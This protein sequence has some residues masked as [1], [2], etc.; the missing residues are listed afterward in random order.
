MLVGKL[1]ESHGCETNAHVN[2]VIEGRKGDTIEE[3]F[4]KLWDYETLGI[5]ET[6]DMYEDLE[7]SICFNG[8]SYSVK[9][10]LEG[11]KLSS[12]N[13]LQTKPILIAWPAEET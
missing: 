13:K 3:S 6:D 10:P 2:L 8:Q 11:W 9:L 7:D 4:K 1:G 5:A 12:T